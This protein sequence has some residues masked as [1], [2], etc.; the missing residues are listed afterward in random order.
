MEH[1]VDGAV[2][3]V[4]DGDVSGLGFRGLAFVDGDYIRFV[5]GLLVLR[6]AE[7]ADHGTKNSE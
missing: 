3:V 2:A 6:H 7:K 1:E 4:D 5:V